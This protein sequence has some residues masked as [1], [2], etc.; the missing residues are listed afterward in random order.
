MASLRRMPSGTWQAIVRRKGYSP[1]FHTFETRQDAHRWARQTK[2][3]RATSIVTLD[4]AGVTSCLRRRP[5]S[6]QAEKV[7]CTMLPPMREPRVFRVGPRHVCVFAG[8]RV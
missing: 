8:V 2:P 1:Q 6:Y 7:G 4:S 5:A 3:T